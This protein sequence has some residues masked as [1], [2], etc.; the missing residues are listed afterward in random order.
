MIPPTCLPNHR[1]RCNSDHSATVATC[2]CSGTAAPP[3]A[4]L[5]ADRGKAPLLVLGYKKFPHQLA[6]RLASSPVMHVID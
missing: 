1:H 6:E 5:G 3:R 4:H 2:P